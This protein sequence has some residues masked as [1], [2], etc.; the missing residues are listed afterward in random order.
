VVGVWAVQGM[1]VKGTPRKLFVGELDFSK[2]VPA[3]G[4]TGEYVI[5]WLGK[6]AS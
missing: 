6:L 5:G 1:M 2:L 4:R 3:I